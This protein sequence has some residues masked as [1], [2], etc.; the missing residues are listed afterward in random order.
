MSSP[1]IQLMDISERLGQM[2]SRLDPLSLEN[3]LA[4]VMLHYHQDLQLVPVG[5]SIAQFR[6]I[7]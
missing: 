4:E 3:I 5:P 2:Y 1:V 7:L 6:Y